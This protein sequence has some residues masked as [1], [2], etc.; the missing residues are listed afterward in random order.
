MVPKQA[1]V[2]RSTPSKWV[3]DSPPQSQST[4]KAIGLRPPMLQN[5]NAV[6]PAISPSQ[7]LPVTTQ[8]L[9]RESSNITADRLNSTASSVG[10][11]DSVFIKDTKSIQQSE[12]SI[13]KK[14]SVSM[15]LPAQTP[16][17]TKKSSEMK[18]TVL[19]NSTTE[20]VDHG[21]SSTKSYG[22]SFPLLTTAV[23]AS[24]SHP[25]KVSQFN[26]AASG[27]QPSAKTS[28]S[29][30]SSMPLTVSSSPM[31]NSSNFA[32]SASPPSSTGLSFLAAM[33]FGTSSITS[34]DNFD[35]KQ[36]ISLASLSSVSPPSTLSLQAPKSLSPS[37]SPPP[38][39]ESSRPELRS[40][41]KQMSPPINPSHSP[42]VSES[43]KTEVHLPTGKLSISSALPL[44]SVSHKPGPEPPTGKTS[45]FSP[46]IS[47]LTSESPKIQLQTSTDKF[48]SRTA[49]D[50]AIIVPLTQL[51]PP[52][53][54]VKLAPPV[55]S[56][57]MTEIST[58]LGYGSQ[59]S[60]N[61]ANPVS[62]IELNVQPKQPDDA[63]VLFGVP[64]ASDNVASGKNANLDVA[65]TEEDE[66]EEEA[67]EN[68]RANEISLGSLGAFGLGS[69]PSS[70]APRANPFGGSFGN[71]GTNQASSGFN[72]TV[73]SGELFRPASFSF[74]SPQPSQQ[75]SQ[76]S[77]PTNLGA[78]S[79][80]F[81]AGAVGQA[82]GGFG[83]P[84]RIGAGQAA[85][86]S[87]L[88]SF[89][90]SR[91]FGAGLPSG[92]ASASSMGGFSSAAAGGGFAGAGSTG[93]GFAGLASGGGGFAGAA[94]GA[95]GF[96][97]MASAGGGFAVAGSGG[98]SGA[99]LHYFL[100]SSLL[101]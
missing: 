48:S 60:L 67:P 63:R 90:Q 77:P 10:K 33:P 17:L 72:M 6:L 2:N 91:Q 62:G 14:S 98:F 69:T 38:V 1:L 85:L 35:V 41:T 71:V 45:P 94:S 23:P 54:N 15:E 58:Q 65:V 74:Q 37:H 13:H 5:N 68:S 88:G 101:F 49:V 32:S 22:S 82:P 53:F 3:N 34:K 26:V 89:G 11:S 36:T 27:S 59:S 56:D 61:V 76:P 78:F 80:G 9:V 55:S 47:P 40:S 28:F 16:V 12:A 99:G 43:L 20:T 19:T 87:V 21:P 4:S 84:A 7:V 64:L 24:L 81:G 18:G 86:G 25:G 83:Q 44:A 79:G 50:T 42:S 31:I 30:A 51:D 93:V 66:M 8:L 92:F 73:P 70:T 95:G 97:G 39:S 52:A 100:L 46:P 75:P 29:Q 57:P 96:G